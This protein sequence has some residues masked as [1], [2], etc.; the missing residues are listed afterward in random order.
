ML[1][2]L[3]TIVV[4]LLL[5]SALYL[6]WLLA[7]RRLRPAGAAPFRSLPWPWLAAAGVLLAAMMLYVVGTRIGGS[8][9]G[10]YVPPRWEGGKI[11]PGHVEPP[12]AHDG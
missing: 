6:L 9:Q 4:P 7:V 8:A 2:I 3:A 1:R 10:V 5:P 11:V 12:A